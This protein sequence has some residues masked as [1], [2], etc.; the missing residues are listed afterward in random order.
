M[1]RAQSSSDKSARAVFTAYGEVLEEQGQSPSDDAVLHRFLFRLQKQRRKNETL[2]QRF[3]RVLH[4][5]FGIDVEIYE[6]VEGAEVT[7]NLDVTR[8]RTQNEIGQRSR[9]GSFDSYFDGTADKVAGVDYGPLPVRSRRL[10]QTDNTNGYWSKRRSRSDTEA[11]LSQPSQLP[12]R[13]KTN[14][15]TRRPSTS[16][17]YQPN[18][19]RSTSVTSRGSLEITRHGHVAPSQIGDDDA[20]DSDYTNRTT[21]LDLSHVQV[22]GLN[23]PLPDEH[24]SVSSQHYAPVQWQPSDTRLM[25]EAEALEEQRL[26]RVTRDCLR[27]WRT[28]TQE[29]ASI[30]NSMEQLAEA[31]DR[32]MLLKLSLEQLRD[33][34]RMRRS[35]RETE[36]FFSRLENRADKAR[37][38]FLLTKAFTHWA[39]S[40][41]DEVQR[42]SVARRHILRTR[43]FNGWRDITAVNELKIQH[44]V[45]GK[46]LRLWR[47]RTASVRESNLFAVL[48]YEENLVHRVYKEW[49]FKFCAVAAPAWRNDRT[50]RFTLQRW[51]EIA[52]VIRERQDWATERQ[53]RTVLRKMLKAWRTKTTTVQL[54]QVQANDFR[55]TTQLTSTLHILRKQTQLAPILHQIQTRIDRRVVR[56]ALHALQRESQLSY[57]ARSVDRLRILH[58]AWTAW[59]DRLRIKALEDRINDRVAV[60]SLYKWTLASRAS[61]FQRVHDRQLKASVLLTWVTKTNQRAQLISAAEQSFASFK[62]SQLQRSFLRRLEALTAEKRAEEFAVVAE[63]QQE[64]KRRIFEKLK[65]RLQHMQQLKQWCEDARFYVLSKHTLRSWSEATQQSRRNRRRDTYAQV[66]R[67][68]KLNLVRRLFKGWVDKANDIAAQKELATRV[69]ESRVAQNIGGLFRQWHNRTITQQQ[70]QIQAINVYRYNIETRQFNTWSSRTRSLRTLERQAEELHRENI[71]V[72]ATS[73]LKK[74][75]WRLWNIQRHEKNAQALYERNFEKHVRAMMRFWSE[76]TV[77]KL[78]HQPESTTPRRRP[79]S[80][81]RNIDGQSRNQGRYLEHKDERPGNGGENTPQL[82]AWAAFDETILDRNDGLD[83]VRSVTPSRPSAINPDP[84]SPMSSRPQPR[85]QPP[86]AFPNSILRQNVYSQSQFAL[87]SPPSMI[88]ENPDIDEDFADPST[89]WSGTPMAPPPMITSKPGYLKTPSKR[90]F[91]RV[92]RTEGPTSPQKQPVRPFHQSLALNRGRAGSE[93]ENNLETMSAP[94]PLTSKTADSGGGITSFQRRLQA[95]GFGRS[96]A[97]SNA[98]ARERGRSGKGRGRVGFGDVSEIG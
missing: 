39:K 17:S 7:T 15:H 24:R 27:I 13:N 76:Q 23:A 1:R 30:H 84:L 35:N 96:V 43:F 79:G 5:S 14:R 4:D 51:A 63:R 21:S 49:F 97:D 22:P 62:R 48:V 70:Q 3:K 40:A 6:D 68:V 90:S 46:F 28:A 25:S 36:R 69:V 61:L 19:K 54:Q 82:E 29:K 41:D 32:K 80:R 86:S 10:S 91:V 37:N 20:N 78:G 74:L 58:N 60:E 42:T 33:T 67:T 81:I 88:P 26:H 50:R 55:R 47:V 2:I 98:I 44:F 73:A 8:T 9:R 72:V 77:V 95:G 83:L 18:R 89:F 71:E 34:A 11:F 66:R 94:H 12:I 53:N 38:L 57:Q 75:G 93:L 92:K 65:E 59:N 31:H 16:I 52:K 64:V 56:T 87:R 45:I 85:S